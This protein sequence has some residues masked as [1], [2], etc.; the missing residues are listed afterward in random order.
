[1]VATLIDTIATALDLTKSVNKLAEGNYTLADGVEGQI[2]YLVLRNG[3]LPA[4]VAVLVAN[5][6]ITGISYIG[7]STLLPFRVYENSNDDYYD[8]TGLCTLIFTDGAWQ[9][10]GGA[11]AV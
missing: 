6:R 1:M 2:M 11:W 10:Q 3:S 5:S 9:Q 4:N 8:S 7:G